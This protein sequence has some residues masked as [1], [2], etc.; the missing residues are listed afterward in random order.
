MFHDT[1]ECP[2]FEEKLSFGSKNDMTNLVNF[3][4]SSGSFESLYFDVLLF[5]IAYKVSAKNYRR[6]ISHDTE[7][8][9]KL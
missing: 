2:K 9:S 7:K 4:V 8:G 3:S 1:E 5:S 6:A